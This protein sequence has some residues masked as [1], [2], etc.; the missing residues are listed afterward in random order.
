MPEL[1][2]TLDMEGRGVEQGLDALT[3]RLSDLSYALGAAGRHMMG[4]V[5]ANFTAGGRP[6]RW[7]PLK[8]GTIRAKG[9][10]APL[11]RTGALSGSVNFK[12]GPDTM[13][14]GADVPYAWVQQH[15]ADGIP[16]RPFLVFQPED[17]DAITGLVADALADG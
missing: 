16:P 6:E 5:A 2:V 9:G 8:P 14:V 7:A 4:S 10:D 3:A 17:A 12:A 11:V 13:V 1:T 15:G